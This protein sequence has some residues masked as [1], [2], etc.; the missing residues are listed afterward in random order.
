[1]GL[2]EQIEED[3]KKLAEM[4]SEEEETKEE[5]AEAEEEPEETED[6]GEEIDAASKEEAPKDDA[7][8][9]RLRRETAAAKKLAEERERELAELRAAQT[10]PAVEVKDDAEPDLEKDPAAWLKWNKR[11]TD[12]QIA[13]VKAWKE[14]RDKTE[15][16][17]QIYT[18]AIN[19]FKAYEADFA[20]TVMDYD[21]RAAFFNKKVTQGF[22]D[23]YP[24]MPDEAIQ[25]RVVEHVLKMAAEFAAQGLNPAEEL[26][27]LASEKYGYAGA[28]S[29]EELKP[30]LA[31]VAANRRRNAGM[32]GAKGRGGEGDISP[33]IAASM[34]AKEFAKLSK[35]DKDKI[36]A[37]LKQMA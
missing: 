30:D 32:A 2:M 5:E 36:Y 4:T 25:S 24:T 20:G 16:Q 18:Q 7:G 27:H 14:E 10:K 28:A 37:Q 9:A 23:L 13:E 35:A 11:Q 19:G 8:Y 26:Y 17:S 33:K 12:S 31:K 29:K 3:K 22:R 1:M 21:D 6:G 34:P 15:R